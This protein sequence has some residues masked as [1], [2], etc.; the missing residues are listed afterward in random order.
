MHSFN[1]INKVWRRKTTNFVWYLTQRRIQVG[2]NFTIE[3]YDKFIVIEEVVGSFKCNFIYT[4]LLNIDRCWIQLTTC[5]GSETMWDIWEHRY[6]HFIRTKMFLELF[7]NKKWCGWTYLFDLSIFL[8]WYSSLIIPYSSRDS[9]RAI[10]F[11]HFQGFKVRILF[12]LKNQNK[13]V[14]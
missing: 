11:F 14:L 5:K 7:F 8:N 12:N 6:E 10:R 9:P 13:S 4:I 1:A 2:V 3:S